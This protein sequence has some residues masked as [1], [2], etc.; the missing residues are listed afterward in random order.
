MKLTNFLLTGLVLWGGLHV[1]AQDIKAEESINLKS[2]SAG[3]LGFFDKLF[4]VRPDPRPRPNPPPYP[5]YPPPPYPG[6]PPPYYP[7]DV[8]CHA[9]DDGTEEH[10]GGHRTCGECLAHHGGCIETC[11]RQVNYAECTVDGRDYYGRVQRFIATGYDYQDAQYRA[12]D[13]CYRSGYRDCIYSGCRNVQDRQEISRR[14]C[15]R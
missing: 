14:Q 9:D 5:G 15:Y 3:V 11:E 13:Q 4:P 7:P 10:W 8:I 6:Y 2:D 12:M 1:H